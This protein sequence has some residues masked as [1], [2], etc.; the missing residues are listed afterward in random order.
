M[1]TLASTRL[2]HLVNRLTPFSKAVPGTSLA[3]REERKRLY[4]IV[5]SPI[6]KGKP[7]RWFVTFSNSDIFEEYIYRIIFND[8]N[9]NIKDDS[10]NILSH[11]EGERF[12][13]NLSKEQRINLL[14][15][16]PA[17]ATRTF[18]IK[19]DLIMKYIVKG[20]STFGK[21]TDHWI[22]IEFQRSLNAHMHMI[23]SVTDET[24][25]DEF[26]V[27]GTKL[28]EGLAKLLKTTC[29]AEVILSLIYNL[30]VYTSS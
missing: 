10:G 21:L 22:R 28:T 12:L 27:E 15:N 2:M 29:T 3:F 6:Y 24:K 7:W 4:S 9:G 23:L 17:V 20:D 19:Q 8:G 25:L 18:M 14:R 11:E 13:K 1:N 5:G 30:L 16:H 26:I